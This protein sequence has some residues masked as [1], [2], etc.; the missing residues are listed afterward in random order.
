[1]Q[2]KP[3]KNSDYDAGTA[4]HV[5]FYNENFKR[6]RCDLLKKIQRS[7][8]G[9]GSNTSSDQ[10]KEIASLREQ[11]SNLENTIQELQTQ[12]DD[13]F[14]RLELDM[15]NRMEQMMMATQNH[16]MSATNA[17]GAAPLGDGD[18]LPFGRGTSIS[19]A[20]NSVANAVAAGGGVFP[21]PRN[22]FSLPATSVTAPAPPAAAP[23]LPPHPKQKQLSTGELPTGGS[24]PA[25]PNRLNSLR[26]IS[27]LRSIS[28]LSRGAS[29][30][31]TGS[32]VFM[33]NGWEDKMFSQIMLGD[34][35]EQE[36]VTE[37]VAI[38]NAAAFVSNDS[39]KEQDRTEDDNMS[40]VS[41]PEMQQ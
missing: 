37:T 13:R 30:D 38:E 33:R 18:N 28:G 15:L 32:A 9:G 25:P 22:S 39:I 40:D 2:A 10:S 26:G 29:L 3:I 16:F 36:G 20:V 8:R 19:S 12:T 1:M 11:V 31:S 27:T 41:N 6:G 24:M 4:K 21:S 14:R 5:T 23:T 35:S 34:S 17:G 7:T